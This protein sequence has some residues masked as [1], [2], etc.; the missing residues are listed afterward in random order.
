ML[1]VDH[2]VARRVS[3]LILLR[4]AVTRTTFVSNVMPLVQLV[5]ESTDNTA[6]AAYPR[7]FCIKI[8]VLAIAPIL[9][10]IMLAFASLVATQILVSTVQNAAAAVARVA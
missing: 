5:P 10:M 6:I 1:N 2:L 4:V 3:S 8:N 7:T 9:F